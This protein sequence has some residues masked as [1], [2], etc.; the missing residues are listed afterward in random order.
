MPHATLCDSQDMFPFL[1]SLAEPAKDA[2]QP[3]L[4]YNTLTRSKERLVPI[5]E[6]YVGMYHCGP[7]VYNY[8]HIGNL[9]AYVFADTLRRTLSQSG[10]T[11]KQVMNITDVGHLT[12][13]ADDGD[14]KMSVGLRREGLPLTLEGMRTLADRY[15]AAF[16][17]DLDA[18]GIK[19]P[20]A[21]PRA[22][23]HIAADL[24]LIATLIEKEYAYRTPDG[25]YFDVTRFP[26]YGK[27]GAQVLAAQQAGA[28]V[29]ENVSKRNQADFAL[30][31]RNDIL[32]WESPWGRGFPGWHIECSAMAMEYLGKELDIHTGGIDH[33]GTHHNNEIAQSEAATGRPFARVWMHCEFVN[34]DGAKISKSLRNDVT[35]RQVVAHG[36]PARA[37]RYFLL[38]AHYR[39]CINFSFPALDAAKT[40]LTRLH[41]TFAEQYLTAPQ[42]AVS[43][44]HL[45]QATW[46][47]YDDLDTPKALAVVWDIVKNKELSLG[48]KRAT[49]LALDRF[50]GLGLAELARHGAST[51]VVPVRSVPTE[52]IPE[53]VRGLIAERETARKER[54]WDRADQ[55]REEIRSHGFVVEDGSEGSVVTR[56]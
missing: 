56:A 45:D 1:F 38:G 48:N 14:D 12:S 19:R 16:L 33:V 41:R 15:T 24:A 51:H 20:H 26:G 6:G 35:L 23:E 55:I 10:L 3:I 47:L 44:T 52:D 25:V 5:R 39:T 43:A 49:L 46:A 9:R 21:L 17:E 4:L 29:A 54:A 31:K 50:L 27:L 30:W 28:R 40:A 8:A 7:T 18:L 22:S 13:D 32:G 42:G 34:I 2:R 36:Y 37:Y 11:V 53:A